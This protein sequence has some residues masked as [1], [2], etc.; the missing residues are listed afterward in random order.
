[1]LIESKLINRARAEND[2]EERNKCSVEVNREDLEDLLEKWHEVNWVVHHHYPKFH[3]E[4]DEI[5]DRFEKIMLA[6]E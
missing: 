3:W 1:M 4:M 5:M 2:M 6:E